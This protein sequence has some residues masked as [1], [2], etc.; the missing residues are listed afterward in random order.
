M[1]E[2]ENTGAGDTARPAPSPD[3]DTPTT[4]P[5]THRPPAAALVIQALA[6]VAGV[7]TFWISAT[8]STDA[9]RELFFLFIAAVV[10]LSGPELVQIVLAAIKRGRGN[11]HG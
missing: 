11:G 3:P 8:T 6:I 10:G 4:T 9:P 1:T 2:P 5:Q 7:V